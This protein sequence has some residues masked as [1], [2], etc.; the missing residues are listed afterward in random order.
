MA[1]YSCSWSVVLQC[2]TTNMC[3]TICHAHKYN[4]TKPG[5]VFSLRSRCWFLSY[6]SCCSSIHNMLQVCTSCKTWLAT[7][8]GTS[9]IWW[10]KV[11]HCAHHVKCRWQLLN[12][13]K[14]HCDNYNH[15]LL[16]AIFETYDRCLKR[17]YFQDATSYPAPG[18]LSSR[19]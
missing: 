3:E 14:K 15:S 9:C 4:V 6:F 8:L 1:L 2:T 10:F 18:C 19:K 5:I 12:V 17:P 11:M 13:H 16:A 7:Q